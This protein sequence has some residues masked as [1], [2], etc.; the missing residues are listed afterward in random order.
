[1]RQDTENG[2]IYVVMIEFQRFS[3]SVGTIGGE[4]H[5]AEYGHGSGIFGFTVVSYADHLIHLG[6]YARVRRFHRDI[7]HI[8]I[9]YAFRAY[10]QNERFCGS[11]RFI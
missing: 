10:L 1:M 9:A 8:K 3:V 4:I 11:G 6:I 5:A 2:F 7:V